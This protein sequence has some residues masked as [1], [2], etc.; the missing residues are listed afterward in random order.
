MDW[1]TLINLLVVVLVPAIGYC[2]KEYRALERDFV[3]FKIKVAEEYVT[4]HDLT[5]IKTD[6]KAILSKLENKADRAR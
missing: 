1:Q 2:V 5:E 3:D 6:I 4:I